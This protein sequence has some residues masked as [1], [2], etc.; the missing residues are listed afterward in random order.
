[1]CDYTCTKYLVFF[2]N[3]LFW[4]LGLIIMAIGV[5]AFADK[6]FVK[7]IANVNADGLEEVA[8]E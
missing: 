6:D 1:M 4:I 8:R 7:N 5:W 2:F 3:F